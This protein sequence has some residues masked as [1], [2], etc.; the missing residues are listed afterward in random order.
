MISITINGEE[1]RNANI[2]ERWIADQINNWQRAGQGICI[3]FRIR[4][5]DVHVNLSA[6]KCPPSGN[7][8]P[9]SDFNTNTRRLIQKWQQKGFSDKEIKPGMVISFWKYVNKF[10]N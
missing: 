1:Q 10:C 7:G 2:S 3:I 5:G 9:I 6:G 4:C 8:K